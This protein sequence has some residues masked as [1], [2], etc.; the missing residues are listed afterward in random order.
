MLPGVPS[1]RPSPET[2]D[3]GGDDPATLQSR[4]EATDPADAESGADAEVVAG[5]QPAAA[6]SIADPVA[7]L[8]HLDVSGRFH[9]DS[10]LGRLYHPGMVSLRETVATESLHISV[11]DN[12]VAAHVDEVAPLDVES[13]GRS[14]YSIRRALL[15]NLAGMAQDLVTILRGRRGDHRSELNCEWQS[16]G[17]VQ[18][19]RLLDPRTS[20]WTVQ[21]EVRVS[22]SLD[23]DRLRGAF[24]ATLGAGARH[25]CLEVVDCDDDGALDAARSRLHGIGVAFDGHP[26]L[27]AYLARHPQGDVLMLN[28]NH[29]AS[30]GFG[31]AHVLGRIAHAY[32]GEPVA[33]LLFLAGVDLPVRPA[34]EHSAIA[35]RAYR[36]VRD[37]VHDALTRPAG[38]AADEARDVP[39][40]GFVFVEL[41]AEDSSALVD[42]QRELTHTGL[43]IAAL[44]LAIAEWNRRHGRS[45]RLIGVLS[46]TNL[47]PED[48]DEDTIGNFCVSTRLTT[49]GRARRSVEST[50]RTIT[51]QTARNKQTRTGIALIAAL[52][53]THLL[54]LW[55]KQSST[56]LR[57]ATSSHDV[58]AAIVCSLGAIDDR[59]SF[60]PDAGDAVELW[61]STPTKSPISVCVGA[62]ILDGRLQLT[63]RYPYRLFSPDAARRFA[64]C[65]TDHLRAVA[66]SRR[67]R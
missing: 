39:E 50:L 44:H 35:L 23:E 40:R 66:N 49:S 33:P 24:A 13:E 26:P 53:R 12:R 57:P 60:G 20:A 67:Q 19:L 32:A 10:R 64:D 17:A 47:R 37:R 21:L 5:A 65:Y 45:S 52:R 51:A 48:W 36:A 9:R 42:A 59:T 14:R 22:G 27:H 6:P 28:L 3:D 18:R 31:A 34:M 58:D 2:A 29:A 61:F 16:D 62:A 43:L 4:L 30:D 7:L 8:H 38:V 25:D 1:S 56:V 15:H 46:P 55:A 63:L 54:P 41:P 11:D